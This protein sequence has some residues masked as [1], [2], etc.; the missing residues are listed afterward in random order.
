M[1]EII[2]GKNNLIIKYLVVKFEHCQYVQYS[3]CI[4]R[5]RFAEQFKIRYLKFAVMNELPS[6]KYVGYRKTISYIYTRFYRPT[7]SNKNNTN[8]MMINS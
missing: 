3:T 8:L 2:P 6:F 1:N 4:T 7:T 5:S